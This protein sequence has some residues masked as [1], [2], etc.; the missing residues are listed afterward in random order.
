MVSGRVSVIIPSRNERFLVPTV[1]DILA[2][3]AGDVEVIVVLDGYWPDPP[4]PDDKRL[5]ILHRG[6]ALG[7]RPAINAASQIAT[8]EFLAKLDAHCMVAEGFDLQLKADYLESNWILIP[9]RYALEPESWSF[10]TSKPGK[11]PVDYH[12]LSYPF[13]R[14]GDPDCGLHGTHWTERRE[15]RKAIELDEEMSSQGSCWFMAREHWDRRLFPMEIHRYGNFIQEMQ[16]LGLKTW[17]GGGALMVTKRTWYAHLY[18]GK[19]YGRGYTMGGTNHQRGAAFCVDYWMNDRWSERVHDL[20][21]LIEKF[22]PVP[23]WPADL[24]AVFSK[25]KAVTA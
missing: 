18:K 8:G 10:E 4:L 11:Y 23:T 6:D 15:A 13:E 5:K 7:M 19:K 21:W 12:Y 20:R 2:K 25:Q 24:D 14:P 17:L 16:E 22:S 1:R 9:R 3:A